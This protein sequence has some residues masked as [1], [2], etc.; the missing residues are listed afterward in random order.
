[1]GIVLIPKLIP[2]QKKKWN[3]TVV[4]AILILYLEKKK[5]WL[6]IWL[7]LLVG[8]SYQNGVEKQKWLIW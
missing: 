8:Q 3:F 2:F 1:M 5:N 7:I 6:K 4:L